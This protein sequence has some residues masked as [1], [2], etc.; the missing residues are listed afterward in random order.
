MPKHTLNTSFASKRAQVLKR[1]NTVSDSSYVGTSLNTSE[2]GSDDT[3]SPVKETFPSKCQPF[4]H[5]ELDVQIYKTKRGERIPKITRENDAKKVNVTFWINGTV[6]YSDLGE[7]GNLGKFTE[8]VAKAK[9]SVTLEAKAPEGLGQVGE[10]IAEKT[11]KTIEFVKEWSDK[12]MGAAFHDEETW[13]L[14]SRNHDDDIS[15]ISGAQHS[16]VKTQSYDDVEVEVLQLTRRLEGWYGE[17]N[18]PVFWN[19]KED[20]EYEQVHPKYIKRGTVLSVQMTFRAYQIPGGRYGMAGDLG[21]HIIVVHNP[22]KKE[23][24]TAPCGV[25]YIPFEL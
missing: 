22:S 5:V 4:D 10:N 1:C 9:F 13:K 23:K 12:A 2:T 11:E 20:G 19:L 14:Q 17:P 25:P 21:K 15:F 16:V 7:N 3:P 18:R 6:R 24:Q 8:D